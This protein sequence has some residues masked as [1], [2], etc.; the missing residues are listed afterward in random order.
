MSTDPAEMEPP[1]VEQ[2]DPV[3]VAEE[4]EE[5]SSD[6]MGKKREALTHQADDYPMRY[7][8]IMLMG[9]EMNLNPFTSLFGFAFLW[10]LSVWCMA[11]PSQANDVSCVA[12]TSSSWNML[13]VSQTLYSNDWMKTTCTCLIHSVWPSGTMLSMTR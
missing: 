6:E 9:T 13:C 2:D 12:R 11:V 10:G 8:S 7:W 4:E 1:K 5:D 3:V